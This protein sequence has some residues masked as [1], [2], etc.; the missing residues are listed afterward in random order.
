MDNDSTVICSVTLEW[1]NAQGAIQRK[2]VHKKATLRLCRNEFRQMIL[3]IAAEK[4]APFKF[5]LKNMSVHNKFMN[6]GKTSMKFQDQKCTVFLSNAPPG[7]LTTFLKLLFVKMTGDKKT[8][9]AKVSLREQLLT[10]QPKV[11]DDISPVT[12][13]D[14]KHIKTS[15]STDTTPSPL[16]RKRKLQDGHSPSPKK[17]FTVSDPLNDEQK[18]VLQACLGGQNVFFTG[19]AGTGKS[20]LLRKIIGALP[21]D[22]TTATAST[23]VA[24]CHIGG[25]TLHQFAGIGSG[26]ATLDRSYQ[27]ASKPSVASIWRK[28][29]HLIIDEISMV[30]A[31]FFEVLS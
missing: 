1:A 7:Q 15:K 30:D 26:E 18:E 16:S 13:A 2:A 9:T 24:A 20:Y 23:G 22:V 21:P 25:I 19:S 31:N 5:P 28:C 29:K 27:M 6:E 17:A 12:V 4:L 14:L 3:E 8:N 11:L 10:S